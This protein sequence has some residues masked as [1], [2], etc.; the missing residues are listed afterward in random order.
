M[1]DA[2]GW[3]EIQVKVPTIS[4]HLLLSCVFPLTL[5]KIITLIW[6]ICF[7]CIIT[8][9]QFNYRERWKMKQF[10]IIFHTWEKKFWTKMAHSLRNLS[11]IM[12]E[13]YIT[14]LTMVCNFVCVSWKNES[15]LNALIMTHCFCVQCLMRQPLQ[16]IFLC[17]LWKFWRNT[18]HQVMRKKTLI[19]RQ[20]KRILV[21]VRSSGSKAMCSGLL[22]CYVYAKKPYICPEMY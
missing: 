16:M 12:K 2:V 4:T 17:S 15:T 11:K 21:K 13:E 22:I 5:K 19:Q 7:T 9:V 6:R 14:H 8:P 20:I 3:N 1:K 10:S 18:K